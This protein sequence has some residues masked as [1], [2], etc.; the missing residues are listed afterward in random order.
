MKYIYIPY[1]V[2]TRHMA[3]LGLKWEDYYKL[4]PAGIVLEPKP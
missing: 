2:W 3:E 4:L 1:E